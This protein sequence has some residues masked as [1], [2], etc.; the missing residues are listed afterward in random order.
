M[1]QEKDLKELRIKH[2]LEKEAKDE[3][4][5]RLQK[6]KE[7]LQQENRMKRQ[8]IEDEAWQTIEEIKDRNKDE[9]VEIIHAGIES[10]SKLT[11]VK[12]THTEKF[13]ERKNLINNLQEQQKKLSDLVQN[14]NEL[15]TNI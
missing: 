4:I 6:Q 13:E 3:E 8:N 1:I 2:K 7:I 5:R 9:L 14:C 12:G 11:N 15:K 10:K